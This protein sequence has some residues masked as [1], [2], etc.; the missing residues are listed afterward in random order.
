MRGPILQALEVARFI[1]DRLKISKVRKAIFSHDEDADEQ[2]K[3]FF[4][5]SG[6]SGMLTREAS[7]TCA[8]EL[9]DGVATPN[10]RQVRRSFPAWPLTT[11]V[12]I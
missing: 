8:E 10:A 6:N 2:Y 9:N 7:I 4:R 11:H 3:L 5:K 1:A 12:R